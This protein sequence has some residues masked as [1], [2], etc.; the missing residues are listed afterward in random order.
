MISSALPVNQMLF[1]S[2]MKAYPHKVLQSGMTCE[3]FGSDVL[4]ASCL[5]R[6][7]YW[8]LFSSHSL[9][10][11]LIGG[12][13]SLP[14]SERADSSLPETRTG[15]HCL[16]SSW[17]SRSHVEKPRWAS[18]SRRTWDQKTGRKIQQITCTDHPQVQNNCKRQWSGTVWAAVYHIWVLPT[19]FGLSQ[20]LVALATAF[21]WAPRTRGWGKDLPSLHCLLF[22]LM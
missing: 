8:Y 9:W 4:F 14:S 10:V 2:F 12:M 20:S 18:A 5:F 7:L 19:E 17:F 1:C 15:C 6:D 22:C 13:P 21:T 11:V 16:Q 3:M